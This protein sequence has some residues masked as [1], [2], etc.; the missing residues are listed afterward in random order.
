ML[1][2]EIF[3]FTIILKLRIL[4]ETVIRALKPE[5]SLLIRNK[6]DLYRRTTGIKETMYL[7]IIYQKI[8]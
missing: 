3:N 1:K 2:I 4:N 8:F 7:P 5:I 6:I